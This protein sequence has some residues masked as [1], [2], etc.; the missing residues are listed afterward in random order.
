MYDETIEALDAALEIASGDPQLENMMV[1]T[2]LM[3]YDHNI[4]AH[5]EEGDLE[6]AAEV[7]AQK[8]QYYLDSLYTR[9]ES[10]PNDLDLKYQLGKALYDHGDQANALPYFQQAQRNPKR[11]VDAVYHMGMCFAAKGQH[12]LARQQ[13]E[14]AAAEIP[15]M[16]ATKMEVVYQLGLMCEAANDHD[17]A[18]NHFKE[19]YQMDI[20]FRDVAE[21]IDRAYTQGG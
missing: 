19:I 18:L 3:I 16:N 15:I 5:T 4:A 11:R 14:L 8:D 21:R 7:Q 12:D 20:G 17:A 13:F 9:V 10:Y 1:E 2:Y 6:K